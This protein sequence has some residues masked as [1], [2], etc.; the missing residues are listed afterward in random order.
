MQPNTLE[1]N[2]SPNLRKMEWRQTEEWREV[3]VRIPN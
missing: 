1:A 2:N 3:D